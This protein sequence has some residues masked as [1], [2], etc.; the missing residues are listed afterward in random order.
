M[1]RN[2]A[3]TYAQILVEIFN[4]LLPIIVFVLIITLIKII[5]DYIKY[6]K[7]AFSVFNKRSKIDIS[8]E[9]LNILIENLNVYYKIIELDNNIIILI[10]E[11]GIYI[12]YL[13]DYDGIISGNIKQEKLIFG[14]NTQ[15]EQNIDNPIYILKNKIDELKNRIGYD[16]LGYVLLKGNC[17]FSVLNRTDIK[18]IPYSAF[19][20][21]FSK[22][23]NNKKISIKEIDKIYKK[24][25]L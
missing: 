12:F 7:T 25:V 13:F 2:L 4:L 16:V 1:I 24:I 20:Y 15:R 9:S 3:D 11:C 23:I 17:I 19:Y 14:E 8:K 6:G 21:H 22:L 10:L 18:V 5:F